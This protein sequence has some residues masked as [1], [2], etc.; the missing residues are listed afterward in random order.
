MKLTLT[1]RGR[2]WRIIPRHVC[3]RA[4]DKTTRIQM[5]T[6]CGVSYSTSCE[7]GGFANSG[8]PCEAVFHSTNAKASECANTNRPKCDDPSKGLESLI[9]NSR[10]S[11]PPPYEAHY[12]RLPVLAT[13]VVSISMNPCS[14]RARRQSPEAL[15]L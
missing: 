8:R 2:S 10:T 11:A 4:E 15:R 13:S 3:W 12:Q 6:V 7:R 5:L 1:S 14:S 9:A